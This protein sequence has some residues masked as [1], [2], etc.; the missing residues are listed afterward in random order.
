[1]TSLLLDYFPIVA[2]VTF[3]NG[4]FINATITFMGASNFNGG[5]IACNGDNL[6]L[7]VP[8]IAGKIQFTCTY[9]KYTRLDSS[10]CFYKVETS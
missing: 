10:N 9:R 1:M 7:T 3:N 5:T 4:S 6:N 2:H 8:T